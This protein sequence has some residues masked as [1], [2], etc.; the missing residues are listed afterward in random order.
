MPRMSNAEKQKSHDRIV[1]AAARILREKGVGATS[2]GDVMNAAGMT[3]GGFYRHFN[4]KEDLIAAA[5]THAVD[6]KVRDME[7]AS[8]EAE[9]QPARQAYIDEYLSRKH[10][11]N[12]GHGCPLATLGAGIAREKNNARA[13]A[14]ATVTR[15]VDLLDDTENE[16]D[17][18]GRAIMALLVGS[19][20]LAR[21][22]D[23]KSD[24]NE[25]L[26]AGRRGVELLQKHWPA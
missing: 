3:H 22:S 14:S 2:V 15:L 11:T 26:D 23:N 7:A 25:A 5:F 12:S 24:V 10:V 18:K 6:D 19:V 9:R 21:L 4:S 17:T 8:T 20:L 16:A 1:D 13:S